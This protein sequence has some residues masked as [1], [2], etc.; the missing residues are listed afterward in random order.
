MMGSH[1]CALRSSLVASSHSLFS[2]LGGGFAKYLMMPKIT[3]EAATPSIVPAKTL[4]PSPGGGTARGPCG[5]N[6]IQYAAF[7]SCNV[8]S[9][10]STTIRSLRAIHSSA[11]S[12]GGM[13]SHLFS[14]FAK[15]GLD[16][17]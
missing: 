13:A 15:V 7:F 8:N 10:Q 3:A 16:R 17:G 12:W 9:F 2:V 5:P 11:C 4:M 6:A 1:F 14:I